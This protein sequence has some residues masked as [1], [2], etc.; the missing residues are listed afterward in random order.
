MRQIFEPVRRCW[1]S[2]PRL[3]RFLIVNC[4][5]GIAAGW[6][7]LAALILSDTAGLRTLIWNSGSPL[8]PVAMLAGGFAITFGS[9]AM[10]AAIMM[11]RNG[12]E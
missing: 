9:A 12:D 3:I 4:A 2:L 1:R 5:S 6:I 7:L 8:L 11:L 10:G